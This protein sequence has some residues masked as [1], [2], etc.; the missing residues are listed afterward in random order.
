MYHSENPVPTAGIIIPSIITPHPYFIFIYI[1]A[2]IKLVN[3]KEQS[4]FLTD[5]ILD[6][7]Q[8]RGW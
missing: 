5:Q 6:Y 2:L 7:T 8:L 3:V 1:L 4:S